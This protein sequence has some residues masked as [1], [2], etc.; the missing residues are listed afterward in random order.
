MAEPVIRV[1]AP[2]RRVDTPPELPPARPSPPET[3]RAGPPQPDVVDPAPPQR[4][5][6]AQPHLDVRPEEPAQGDKE[7]GEPPPPD[8]PS[9]PTARA[10]H[11]VEALTREAARLRE[12]GLEVDVRH[13]TLEPPG[14]TRRPMSVRD[15]TGLAYD[16]PQ[17]SE[18]EIAA[19]RRANPTLV[20]D[21]VPANTEVELRGTPLSLRLAREH[22]Q[23]AQ[24]YLESE[25]AS[26][27]RDAQREAVNARL[28][29]VNGR[30]Q[31]QAIGRHLDHA[32][33]TTDALVRERRIDAIPSAYEHVRR[34][35]ARRLDAGELTP[36]QAALARRHIDAAEASRLTNAVTSL[37]AGFA[38][39]VQTHQSR[40]E[41]YDPSGGMAV[42][43]HSRQLDRY[44]AQHREP[45]VRAIEQATTTARERLEALAA[46][47]PDAGA[48]VTSAIAALERERQRAL[49]QVHLASG[50]PAAAE[51]VFLPEALARGGELL[52]P[53]TSMRVG[54]DGQPLTGIL[55]LFT[56]G[57]HVPQLSEARRAEVVRQ[58]MQLPAEQRRSAMAGLLELA[59]IY[60]TRDDRGRFRGAQQVLSALATQAG[61][62]ELAV[63]ATFVEARY[64]S[65]VRNFGG[66]RELLGR[67]LEEARALGDARGRDL[68]VEATVGLIA[69]HR[70]EAFAGGTEEA[71]HRAAERLTDLRRALE[72]NGQGLSR[73]QVA[74]L[75]VLEAQ[76]YLQQGRAEL[77]DHVFRYVDAIFRD[78]PEAHRAA[79]QLREEASRPGF[80][81]AM[82]QVLH[83]AGSAPPELALSYTFGAG[84][85]GAGVGFLFGNGPGAAGGFIAGS[86]VGATLAAAHHAYRSW[87][88]V[89]QAYRTG[90]SPLSFMDTLTDTAFLGL[91]TVASTA[92]L[93]GLARVSRLGG[94]SALA[95]P[96]ELIGALERSVGAMGVAATRQ[97]IE[98]E[99]RRLVYQAFAEGTLSFG[100]RPLAL[101]GATAI[102]AP[103]AAEAVRIQG[104]P[105]GPEREAASRRFNESL[106]SG[107]LITAATLGTAAYAAR[108]VRG[109][110]RWQADPGIEPFSIGTRGQVDPDPATLGARG[111]AYRE[112]TRLLET[113][114]GRVMTESEGA[115]LV[116]ALEQSAADLP[117]SDRAQLARRVLLELQATRAA[118]LELGGRTSV[119]AAELPQL[120]DRV[121]RRIEESR[122]APDS[123]PP[124]NVFSEAMQAVG[125]AL[126]ADPEARGVLFDRVTAAEIRAGLPELNPA[127]GG[128]LENLVARELQRMR[129]LAAARE[130]VTRTEVDRARAELNRRLRALGL[131]NSDADLVLADVQREAF[132]RGATERLVREQ[133]A[134]GAPLTDAELNSVIAEVADR[135]GLGRSAEVVADLGRAEG[136]RT[137]VRSHLPPERWTPEM[138]R[139]AFLAS[140]PAS[141]RAEMGTLSAAEMGAIFGDRPGPWVASLIGDM[142]GFANFARAN[143]SGARDLIHATAM[144]ENPRHLI[145]TQGFENAAA[146][147]RRML[148]TIEPHPTMR[149]FLLMRRGPDAPA[150]MPEVS[151]MQNHIADH[152]SAMH[153]H[154]ALPPGLFGARSMASTFTGMGALNP[155]QLIVNGEPLANLNRVLVFGTHGWH[156]GPGMSPSAAAR[157]IADTIASLPPERRPLH[158]VLDSC[159]Q[160]DRRLMVIGRSSGHVFRTALNRHLHGMGIDP[161]NVLLAE[162]PGTVA[163]GNAYYGVPNTMVQNTPMI[164]YEPGRGF[165]FG[166]ERIE[167]SF[168]DDVTSRAN[169]PPEV[170]YFG[171]GMAGLLTAEVLLIQWYMDRERR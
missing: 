110:P 54:A 77:A 59:D 153:Y 106:A 38:R 41:G 132:Q 25:P 61:D 138:R 159:F 28:T 5:G 22:L 155:R 117:G 30:L 42:I 51:R 144:M 130:P 162:R 56:S 105:P 60:G 24:T 12:A 109:S 39:E 15:L 37:G 167:S 16:N 141:V 119:T 101:A 78:V 126:R 33:T 95:R 84:L 81:A 104:M 45:T 98:R 139:D 9:V 67:A 146:R 50:D 142:P 170:L 149:N 58:I 134:R 152:N 7:R 148:P 92:P 90:L 52:R 29:E 161:V 32:N 47:N 107:M 97:E 49:A 135:V 14:K 34:D 143:P 20:R 166:R 163:S 68:E 57:T 75:A 66:A 62:A 53:D 91:N 63:R 133:A 26:P 21:D 125:R 86:A 140:A 164:R 137:W 35:V 55:S 88:Q 89:A 46:A 156:G 118:E 151:V 83:A 80:V 82:Q 147:A 171:A 72:Q 65:R 31:A 114:R 94:V 124:T 79:A 44:I 116:R 96:T 17:P 165:R 122:G 168:R 6:E 4:P 121:Q 160:T 71:R 27:E 108:M 73:D 113:T 64:A 43:H 128:D 10:Q 40:I 76:T 154:V 131:H 13:A 150:W 127:A 69:T 87:D 115:N 19:F 3:T 74:R 99:A 103:L 145:E 158:V 100:G 1:E 8:S 169:V 111:E 11:H 23:L 85:A 2:R 129:E 102:T 136:F 48:N 112:L 18:A 157:N 70:A 120:I 123:V 36:E 93:G